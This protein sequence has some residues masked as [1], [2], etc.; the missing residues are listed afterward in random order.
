M[1][2]SNGPLS[3]VF[4]LPLILSNDLRCRM[5]AT[6]YVSGLVFSQ[7]AVDVDTFL[8]HPPLHKVGFPNGI[9]CF[10]SDTQG[11]CQ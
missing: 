1:L 7:K 2:S 4:I 8:T 10:Y 11:K 6:R 5:V 9:S 3:C